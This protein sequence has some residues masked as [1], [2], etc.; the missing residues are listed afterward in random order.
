MERVERDADSLW[1]LG[2]NGQT[3]RARF[4]ID[5]TGRAVA[6]ARKL[7]LAR[8]T[9]IDNLLCRTVR[10]PPSANTDCLE[11]FSFV[12]A[13]PQGWWHRATEP[14]GDV[15]VAFF[16]DA[17]L[18]VARSTRNARGFLA[19]LSRTTEARRGIDLGSLSVERPLAY[20]ARTQR[21]SRVAGKDWCAIGDAVIALDPLCSAGLFNALYLAVRA[22]RG[23]E[24]CLNGD[25]EGIVN[26]AIDVESIW[27]AYL[28]KRL[29]T[30]AEVGRYANEPFWRRRAEAA[31]V[32]NPQSPSWAN[33]PRTSNQRLLPD[34][35]PH[36]VVA[37]AGVCA[38]PDYQPNA[39]TD[40]W[41]THD[42]DNC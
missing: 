31:A 18:P 42:E 19:E 24:G 6:L 30:Y 11:G 39:T 4:I 41:R 25:P 8:P 40:S 10:L 33:P 38:C 9:A 26:Y 29:V 12:E 27:R 3:L 23:V 2:C 17:D 34:H 36:E 13:S 5:A 20:S 22:A 37:H 7:G 28:V 35:L 15:V 32:T 21:L 14:D 1:R 16:T